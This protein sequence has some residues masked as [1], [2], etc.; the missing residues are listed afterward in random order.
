MCFSWRRHTK[1]REHCTA[2]VFVLFERWLYCRRR[3]SRRIKVTRI[4]PTNGPPIVRAVGFRVRPER[5]LVMSVCRDR[6][7]QCRL[8]G[9]LRRQL[10]LRM[11][12]VLAVTRS[13]RSGSERWGQTN[14]DWGT[15]TDRRRPTETQGNSGTTVA[16]AA[17]LVAVAWRQ[18]LQ[19]ILMLGWMVCV[20]ELVPVCQMQGHAQVRWHRRNIVDI[21]ART[22]LC[23]DFVIQILKR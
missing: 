15:V 8:D 11:I 6:R 23:P 3:S 16:E 1:N 19:P 9:G 12:R 22:S 18:R 21:T 7:V 2:D 13:R 10:I 14:V 5:A 20:L 17:V 4:V